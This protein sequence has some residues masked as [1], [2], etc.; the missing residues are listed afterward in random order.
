MKSIEKIRNQ[1]PVFLHNWSEKIDVVSDFEQIKLTGTEYRA[2]IPPYL[3]EELWKS[4]KIRMK[5]ALKKYRGVNIL[6]ASYAYEDYSGSAFVLFEKDGELYEV[7]GSHCSCYGLE[8]QWNPE[9]T[10]LKA[11]KFRLENGDGYRLDFY[12]NKLKEFLGIK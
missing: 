12:K 7:H 5:E 1:K 6:F 11:L 4:K 2:K 10:S 8:G 3:N 9:K